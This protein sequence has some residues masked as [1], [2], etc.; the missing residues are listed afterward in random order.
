[1]IDRFGPVPVATQELIQTITLRRMG[2]AF[3]IEKLLL[4]QGKM[5]CH[6]SSNQD[7]PF[8]TSGNFMRMINYV[9]EHPR[10]A[11]LKESAQR[12]SLVCDKVDSIRRAL[13]VLATIAG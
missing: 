5:V 3:G 2:K 10:E 7:N 1:M 8:Y 11:H 13:E 9:Q 12:L 4:K 6:F